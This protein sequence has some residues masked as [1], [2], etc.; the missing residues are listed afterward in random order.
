MCVREG[1]SKY[2]TA[3][4]S[5]S[6]LFFVAVAIV[7]TSTPASYALV[8]VF[9]SWK[10]VVSDSASVVMTTSCA[11]EIVIL[12]EGQVERRLEY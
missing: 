4:G 11:T 2:A 12:C 3:R 5:K 7:F 6:L 1:V 8:Y 10:A 9:A